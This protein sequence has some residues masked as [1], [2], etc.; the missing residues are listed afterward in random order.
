[1]L[2]SEKSEPGDKVLWVEVHWVPYFHVLKRNFIG[3]SRVVSFLGPSYKIKGLPWQLGGT[4]STCQ[5]RRLGFDP[6]D[7]KITR[8]RKW[9]PIPVFLSGKIPWTEEPSGLQS[10]GLLQRVRHDLPTKQHESNSQETDFYPDW[11]DINVHWKTYFHSGLLCTH[12][13]PRRR[14]LGKF[15]FCHKIW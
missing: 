14:Y 4:E 13:L 3:H 12:H 9:Q 5:C 2:L 8:K 6:W 7:E 11:Q 15:F 10:M 1:M